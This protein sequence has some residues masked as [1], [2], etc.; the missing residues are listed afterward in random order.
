MYILGGCKNYQH[1]LGEN[2]RLNMQLIIGFEGSVFSVHFPCVCRKEKEK[3]MVISKNTYMT[4]YVIS[5][6]VG[7]YSRGSE[8]ND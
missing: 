1:I 4:V 5:F 2:L 6:Q 8:E 7:H 3:E